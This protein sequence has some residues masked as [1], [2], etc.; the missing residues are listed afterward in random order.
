MM[1]L[2]KTAKE[3]V[4]ALKQ[5]GFTASWKVAKKA[6]EVTSLTGETM[7]I[8]T[9][10]TADAADTEWEADLVRLLADLFEF[11][12]TAET[13]AATTATE[14]AEDADQ[15]AFEGSLPTLPTEAENAPQGDFEGFSE[16]QTGLTVSMPKDG[17]TDGAI[18]RLKDLIFSKRHLIWKALG[19]NNLRIEVSEDRVSFP[20]W[21]RIPAPE[22]TQAYT[23]FIA[24]ISAFAK[25]AKRVNVT[26]RSEVESEKYAFRGFLLRLGF[27]GPECAAQRKLLLRNLSGSASFPN[28]QKYT[29]FCSAQKAKRDAAK[30]VS[31]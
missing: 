27:I 29:A 7:M 9:N 8:Y 14:S 5:N 6:Y 17:F 19:V 2:K 12:Q 4:E 31:A 3:T 10:G 13:E 20:W 28:G 23:A 11:E 26:E 18:K 24:A 22:E 15:G 21:D 25:N 30:E 1:K 16:E